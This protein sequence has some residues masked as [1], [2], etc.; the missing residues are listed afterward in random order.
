VTLLGYAFMFV[1]GAAVGAIGRHFLPLSPPVFEGSR[2]ELVGT[3]AVTVTSIGTYPPTV[4]WRRHDGVQGRSPLTIF[5]RGARLL[6]A[7]EYAVIVERERIEI[8][9][10][11]PGGKP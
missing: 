10:A 7:A 1:L 8:D 9:L 2:W 3:G 11:Q 6:T 4:T 5:Q